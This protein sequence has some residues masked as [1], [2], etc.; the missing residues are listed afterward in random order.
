MQ[1]G[2][3]GCDYKLLAG[4]HSIDMCLGKLSYFTLVR[5]LPTLC[6]WPGQP[7]RNLLSGRISLSSSP[8]F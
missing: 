8:T 4:C 3:V 7:G 1:R 5:A 6:T 2:V